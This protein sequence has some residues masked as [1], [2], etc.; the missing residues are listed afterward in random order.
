MQKQVTWALYGGAIPIGDELH[1]DPVRAP[2]YDG[3]EDDVA[4]EDLRALMR[5]E[6]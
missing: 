5:R 2:I 1:A 6:R 3:G 4:S